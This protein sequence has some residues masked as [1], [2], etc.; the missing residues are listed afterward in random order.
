ME[1][2]LVIGFDCRA[3]WLYTF[4][5]AHRPFLK[6][7]LEYWFSIGRTTWPT[8][9]LFSQVKVN[10]K[11]VGTA[12]DCNLQIPYEHQTSDGFWDDLE[13]MQS[14]MEENKEAFQ[15]SSWVIAL[16]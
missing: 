15:R 13:A 8:V 2:E 14:F 4:D 6:P 3:M 5:E 16:T 12:P 10:G 1:R 11:D 7:D 9:F